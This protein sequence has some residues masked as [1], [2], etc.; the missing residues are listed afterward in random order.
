MPSRNTVREFAPHHYYH[1]YNRGVEKRIIFN[2]DQDYR[3]FLALLK[4]YLLVDENES[5]RSPKRQLYTPVGKEV[6]LLAYCLMPNHFHLLFYQLDK[7]GITKLMRRVIT[8]YVMYYNA[9]HKRV[10]ALFQGKYKA[11][12]VNADDYLSH[13]SRYIHLNPRDYKSWPYSSLGYYK[14]NKDSGWLH[15]DKVLSIFNND[16]FKY[17]EF[18]QDY[19]PVMHELEIIK[20]QLADNGETSIR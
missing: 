12:L 16:N 20:W 1:V 7:D 3:M 18:L 14:G 19:Q 5:H 9:K 10:G 6:E 13:I 15:K 8:G 11:S 2:D 17:L 4:R